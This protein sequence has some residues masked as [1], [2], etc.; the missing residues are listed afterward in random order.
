MAL[1]TIYGPGYHVC[2]PVTTSAYALVLYGVVRAY[3]T[4]PATLHPGYT[5]AATTSTRTSGRP[6]HAA[7]GHPDVKNRSWG[8]LLT[9]PSDTSLDH[10]DTWVRPGLVS[11]LNGTLVSYPAGLAIMAVLASIV[12]SG[13]Y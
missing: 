6:G 3:G 4:H 1:V 10:V 12:R 11:P 2:G 7:R 9:A 5:M 8:S 13:L